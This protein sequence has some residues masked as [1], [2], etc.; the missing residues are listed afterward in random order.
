MKNYGKI[1]EVI[2]N[3]TNLGSTE[4]FNKVIRATSSNY[5]VMACDD[6]WFHRGWD[7]A[8]IRLVNENPDCGISTFFNFPI[9][10]NVK[11]HNSYSY[12]HQSTGLAGS[13]ISRKL[14]DLVGGFILPTDIKMGYFA[15]GFCTSSARAKTA[16]RAQ[17]LTNPYYGEQ[18][19]RY[20]PGVEGKPKLHQEYL[21]SEYNA[22]RGVEK[23]KH[24]D[25]N[26]QK[27]N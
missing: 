18:M 21:Y 14:F 19:D 9:T 7:S 11:V 24:L 2:I 5:F 16:R 27:S 1:D 12:K 15:R 6:I 20:N 17:Y 25:Y 10:S 26:N 3:E 13:I 22:R 4:S 23:R 8:A